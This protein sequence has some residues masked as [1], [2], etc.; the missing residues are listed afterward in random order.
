VDRELLDLEISIVELVEQS[1]Q[2]ADTRIAWDLDDELLWGSLGDDP[3]VIED[4][5][6]VGEMVSLV[7]VL[8]GGGS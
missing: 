8:G 6:P 3:A 4:R 2:G 7:E 5:D 1:P